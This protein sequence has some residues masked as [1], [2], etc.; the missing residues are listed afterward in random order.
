MRVYE[1]DIDRLVWRAREGYRV[2]QGNR[3]LPS[4]DKALDDI[5]DC[6]TAALGQK[7]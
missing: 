3:L 4:Q 1:Q 6:R 5:G 2:R 7:G